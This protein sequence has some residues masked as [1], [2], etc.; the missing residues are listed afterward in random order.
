MMR[1]IFFSWYYKKK[2]SWEE[3]EMM[4]MIVISGKYVFYCEKERKFIKKEIAILH[5]FVGLSIKVMMKLSTISI[6]FETP[7]L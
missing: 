6:L 2:V 7:A 4:M 5:L 1:N 3:D